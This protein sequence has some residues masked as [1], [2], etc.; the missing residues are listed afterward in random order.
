MKE[1][2]KQFQETEE[3]ISTQFLNV[4]LLM[5]I[6]ILVNFTFMSLNKTSAIV[7]GNKSY[8]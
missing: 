6:F 7:F 8:V 4:I 5:S 2:L 1:L 3:R